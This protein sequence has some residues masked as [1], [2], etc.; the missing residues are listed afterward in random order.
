MNNKPGST[1]Y[2][3]P[4][5]KQLYTVYILGVSK[6]EGFAPNLMDLLPIDVQFRENYHKSYNYDV[7]G[8]LPLTPRFI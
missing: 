7:V 1:D 2:C 4:R 8:K 5:K 6:N 3:L